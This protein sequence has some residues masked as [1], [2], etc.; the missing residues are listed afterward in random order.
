MIFAFDS[1][2]NKVDFV[3]ELEG[4]IEQM[5]EQNGCAA[6]QHLGGRGRAGVL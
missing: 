3:K 2:V 6:F 5:D 4:M 1:D